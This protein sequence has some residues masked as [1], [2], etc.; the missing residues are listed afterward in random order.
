MVANGN[1]YLDIFNRKKSDD[2]QLKLSYKYFHPALQEHVRNLYAAHGLGI[3][4][5]LKGELDAGQSILEK[6]VKV[7][8]C[9]WNKK[10][11]NPFLS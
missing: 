1:F 8:L 9:A 6:V 10:C 4:C 7:T 3:V 2:S 5:A 11:R